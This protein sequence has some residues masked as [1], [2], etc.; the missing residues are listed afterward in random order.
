MAAGKQYVVSTG[1]RQQ[2]FIEVLA[3]WGRI[4]AVI[5]AARFILDLNCYGLDCSIYIPQPADL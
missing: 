4:T 5:A 3:V 1:L 2:R